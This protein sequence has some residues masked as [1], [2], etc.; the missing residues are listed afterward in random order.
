M[1][2]AIRTPTVSS[3]W[4]RELED[5]E[6]LVHTRTRFVRRCYE[7]CNV[8]LDPRGWLSPRD[9][10]PL[11][12]SCGMA[13][14]TCLDVTNWLATG[15]AVRLSGLFAYLA[16]QKLCRQFGRDTGATVCGAVK[17]AKVFGVCREKI[18]PTTMTYRDS[19]PGRAL[20]DAARH[21][22]VSHSMLGTYREV[23]VFLAAGLGAVLLAIPWRQSLA[24]AGAVVEED[25]GPTLGWHA[26]SVVGIADEP[27]DERGRPY[28][29][30]ANSHGLD[31]GNNGFTLVAP[32]LFD[33]WGGSVDAL[34]I[35]LSDL[36]VYR[37]RSAKPV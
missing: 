22:L 5:R 26:V 15:R 35:G 11:Q 23:F 1:S 19:I 6:F 30:V 36:D 29:V 12:A 24:S 34:M 31:W 14:A 10:G 20:R 3:G 9:Q 21:R 2:I 18:V 33:A 25:G 28:L 4:L 37:A 7:P 27:R 32:R 8:P 16:A 17:A 13:L